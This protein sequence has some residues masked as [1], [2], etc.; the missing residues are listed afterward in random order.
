MSENAKYRYEIVAPSG[1]EAVQEGE[2]TAEQHGDVCRV[3]NGESLSASQAREAELR[4]KLEAAESQQDKF[5]DDANR[6]YGQAVLNQQ[7]AEAAEA[8]IKASQEQEPT[9]YIVTPDAL[10][11]QYQSPIVPAELADLHRECKWEFEAERQRRVDAERD[12]A[13]LRE[14]LES[15]VPEWKPLTNYGQ[16]KVGDRIMFE[17]CGTTVKRTIGEILFGG[18][19]KE[20]MIYDRGRNYYIITSMALKGEGSQKNVRYFPK[21]AQP[22]EAKQ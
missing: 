9:S 6:F 3:L 16:V 22:K 10:V 2:I 5:K 18:T 12:L 17:L 20:E 4:E 14:L 15:K 11:A 1:Y 7:Q 21:S 13:E 8:R 19:D